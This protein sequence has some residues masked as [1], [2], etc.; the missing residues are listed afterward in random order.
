MS[1]DVTTNAPLIHRNLPVVWDAG[2][3]NAFK[4]VIARPIVS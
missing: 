3:E 1:P 2:Q 4:P